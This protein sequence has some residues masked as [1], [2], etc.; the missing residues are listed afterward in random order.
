[1]RVSGH[2]LF[3]HCCAVQGCAFSFLPSSVWQN[4]VRD[5]T[6]WQVRYGE[7]EGCRPKEPAKFCPVS[8][9]MQD[10]RT[11]KSYNWNAN[12]VPNFNRVEASYSLPPQ[13]RP[14]ASRPALASGGSVQLAR[15]C[16]ARNHG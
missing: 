5:W 14:A 15:T 4:R 6:C 8:W 10:W 11:V 1:M 3:D 2:S 13:V 16:P 12:P 7:P 9:L